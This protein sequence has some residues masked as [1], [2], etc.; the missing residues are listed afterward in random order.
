[1]QPVY[2]VYTVYSDRK[3]RS[4]LPAVGFYG[5]GPAFLVARH[6]VL[7]DSTASENA[8]RRGDV[9]WNST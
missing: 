9:S 3:S 8:I 2:R 4:T 7:S 1:M 6:Y 5:S